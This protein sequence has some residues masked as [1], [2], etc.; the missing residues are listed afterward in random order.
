MQSTQF[1]L[2]DQASNKPDIPVDKNKKIWKMKIPLK[3][4]KIGW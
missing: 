4:K 1:Q 2:S 3:I